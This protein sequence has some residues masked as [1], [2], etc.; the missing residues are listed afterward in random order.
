MRPWVKSPGVE[1][2]GGAAL[3]GGDEGVMSDFLKIFWGPGF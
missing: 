3:V 2:I 1:E